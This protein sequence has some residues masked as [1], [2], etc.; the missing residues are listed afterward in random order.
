MELWIL[1]FLSWPSVLACWAVGPALICQSLFLLGFQSSATVAAEDDDCGLQRPLFFIWTLQS[2]GQCDKKHS[3]SGLSGCLPPSQ[4][5]ILSRSLVS[6]FPFRETWA[7]LCVLSRPLHT[8]CGDP[9]RSLFDL[10]CRVLISWQLASLN[11]TQ[12]SR[13]SDQVKAAFLT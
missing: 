9:R 10:I 12:R 11:K 3:Y 1:H 13:W 2:G 4:I 6:T 5:C 7:V 8:G